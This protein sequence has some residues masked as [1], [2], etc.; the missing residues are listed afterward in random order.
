[1]TTAVEYIAPWIIAYQDGEHRILRDGA[2]VVDG[3]RIV[4]VGAPGAVEVDRTEH[5]ESVIAPG[6]ISLHAHMQESP[7][8]KGIAED[9]EKR[10]FW[11]TNLIEILPPRSQAL[12]PEDARTC[13]RV[14]IAEHLR[15]GTTTVMQMGVESE[16]IADLCA[17]VG[18]RAYI[19]ESYRS[20]EWFTDDGKNVEYRWREDDGHAAFERALSFALRHRN[21]SGNELV[22]GFLNPSQVDTCSESLLRRTREASDEHGLL[23]QIH[24]A[25]SYSEFHEMTRR[26]GRTPIEWL[27]DI[28][29]LGDRTLIGHGL[30][31]TGTSWTNFHGDDLGLLARSGTSV[32]YNPWVFARNG[33]IMES[34]ERYREAG[35]SVCFGTDTT[36]QSMLWSLRWASIITKVFEHRAD[37]ARARD[38]FDSATLR[39]AEILGRS[40]LGRIEAGA[41]ADLVFWKTQSAYVTPLRDPIRTIV[42]Y[43]EHEDIEAVMVDGTFSLADGKVVGLDE[44]ADLRELQ[45]ISERVWAGW[46]ERDWAHRTI[47]AHVPMSYGEFTY[48]S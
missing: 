37:A 12:T 47:D 23:M 26:H 31:L 46:S 8:D 32:V 44:A 24:A 27:D 21:R 41:K 29:F 30:F 34:Y 20:G 9:I 6:F 17:S 42:Y 14:S 36:T 25:Q 39:A 35:V 22:T 18:L 5:T 4:H 7:V 2:V 43:A 45:E 38:V 16:A 1:M 28:G 11:G 33:I 40:D 3:D 19:A 48:P 15:T 10:Q 13:A